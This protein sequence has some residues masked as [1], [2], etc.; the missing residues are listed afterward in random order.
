M[1][2]LLTT[3]GIIYKLLILLLNVIRVCDDQFY[4]E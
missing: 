4:L 3:K 1:T 2:Y